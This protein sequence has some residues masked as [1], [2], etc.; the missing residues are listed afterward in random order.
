MTKPRI[1][2]TGEFLFPHLVKDQP[3]FKY[4][5]EGEYHVKLILTKEE[6]EADIKAIQDEIKIKV[7]EY[8]KK[9][10]NSTGAIKR[11]SLP[12]KNDVDDPTKIVFT[13]KMKASGTNSKTVVPFKQAPQL[14]N[15]DASAFDTSKKIY[16]GT[17]G[18]IKYYPYG[19]YVDAQGVGCSLR[20][21][22]AQITDL[23]EGGGPM[24]EPIKTE[25]S[26]LPAPEK[27]VY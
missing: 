25:G 6:A 23:V 4:K 7:A 5:P 18:R 10:P 14:S 13:F 19:Y 2:P 26:S 11:A 1:T 17:K 9:K 20:L 21:M 22:G 24:F 15:A 16:G 27:A 8:H 12:Y 3:D